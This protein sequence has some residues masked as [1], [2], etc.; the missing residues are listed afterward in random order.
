MVLVASGIH[1]SLPEVPVK[2]RGWLKR[3]QIGGRRGCMGELPCP[4]ALPPQPCPELSAYWLHHPQHPI[5]LEE[6][7]ANHTQLL[8]PD[9]REEEGSWQEETEASKWDLTEAGHLRQRM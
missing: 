8:D 4:Q 3:S 5:G 1:Q 7:I 9:S 2:Q 6:V